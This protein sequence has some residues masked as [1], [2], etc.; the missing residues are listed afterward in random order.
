MNM[1]GIPQKDL[2]K[3]GLV[4]IIDTDSA[5]NR[6]VMIGPAERSEGRKTEDSKFP[7][8]TADEFFEVQQPRTD[9]PGGRYYSSTQIMYSLGRTHDNIRTLLLERTFANRYGIV[10]SIGMIGKTIVF[11]EQN[12]R[13]MFENYIIPKL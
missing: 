13:E 8:Q 9:G 12:V 1:E 10:S 2:D 3:H 6:S 5:G 4:L 7:Y 11:S